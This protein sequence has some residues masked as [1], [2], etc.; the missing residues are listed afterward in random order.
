MEGINLKE[1]SR[2]QLKYWV[3]FTIL[4]DFE[5]YTSYYCVKVEVVWFLESKDTQREKDNDTN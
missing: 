1:S 3:F 4:Q 5:M 2:T